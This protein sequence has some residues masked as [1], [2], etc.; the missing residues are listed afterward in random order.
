[1]VLCQPLPH[2]EAVCIHSGNPHKYE[3][4]GGMVF[5]FNSWEENLGQDVVDLRQFQFSRLQKQ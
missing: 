3:G 2:E 5:R 1:M 4:G